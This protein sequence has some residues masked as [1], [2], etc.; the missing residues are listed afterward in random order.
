[1]SYY[2]DEFPEPQPR[3]R[4]WTI[5]KWLLVIGLVVGSFVVGVVGMRV[6]AGYV[7]DLIGADETTVVAGDEVEVTILPGSS[8]RQIGDVLVE[9]G[10]I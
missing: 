5:V 8:A 3:R 10:V 6:L 9:A 2:H 7:G 4:W 1:M